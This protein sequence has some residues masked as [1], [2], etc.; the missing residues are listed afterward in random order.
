VK[1]SHCADNNPIRIGDERE[2]LVAAS[3]VMTKSW[4]PAEGNNYPESGLVKPPRRNT[5]ALEPCRYLRSK[6]VAPLSGGEEQTARAISAYAQRACKL[7]LQMGSINYTRLYYTSVIHEGAQRL[8]FGLKCIPFAIRPRSVC[9][10]I[11]NLR[12]FTGYLSVMGQS[13]VC[14]RALANLGA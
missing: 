9:F 3:P 6:G 11:V 4:A 8:Y 13:P 2:R 1:S 10:Q 14:S 5:R 7:P 12:R